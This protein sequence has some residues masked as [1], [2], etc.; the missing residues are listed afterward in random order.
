[1]NMTSGY[2][3]SDAPGAAWAYNDV[4]S[5]LRNR[6]LG[7]IL[8]EPLDAQLRTRLAPLQ[9]EDAALLTTRGGY[10]I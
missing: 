6:L 10:G 3:I 2:A 5:Q 8:G 9:L 7:S 4:A 1:M